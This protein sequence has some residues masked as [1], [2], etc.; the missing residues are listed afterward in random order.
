MFIKRSITFK[1]EKRK[2]NGIVIVQNVP[3]KIRLS[4]LGNK[5]DLYSGYRVDIAKWN[6]SQQRV[7]NGTT[8]VL[9][10]SASEI[11]NALSTQ[12]SIIQTIFKSYEVKGEIPTP[13]TL[14][15]E[16]NLRIKPKDEKAE[17]PSE[18]SFFNIYDE[19]LAEGIKLNNWTDGT[20]K[21]L[22]TVRSHIEE[23]DH[24]IKLDSFDHAKLYAYLDFLLLVRDFKNTTLQKHLKYLKWFL[25]WGVKNKYIQNNDF[26]SFAPK[27]KTV[28]KKVIF[29]TKEEIDLIRSFPLPKEKQYLE[30]VRDV[31]IFSCFSS[32]RYSDIFKLTKEDIGIASLEFITTKTDDNIV[33]EFN[34]YS[35]EI[36]NKYKGVQYPGNKALPVISNQ[37]FNDYLKELGEVVGLNQPVKTT[38]YKGNKRYEEITPKYQKLSSHIGRRSF[39]CNGLFLGI[40]VHIMMRWTGHSDFDSMKPYIDVVESMRSREMEKFNQM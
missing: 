40:P 38:Y 34:K 20:V 6:E 13:K 31:L 9:K 21:K 29:L 17:R 39:I 32:L 4:F 18:I 27:I 24:N 37:N 36:L 5:M 7:K 11:N 15:E 35:R 10:Q 23:F 2:H 12:D 26:E 28:A 3:I 25:R 19:F 30:R 14:R 22:K 8:N 1:P 16:I 33:V